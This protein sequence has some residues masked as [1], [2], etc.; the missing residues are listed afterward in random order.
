VEDTNPKPNNPETRRPHDW[1]TPLATSADIRR[2]RHTDVSRDPRYNH[3]G[4]SAVD[5]DVECTAAPHRI[6]NWL[7]PPKETQEL[8]HT[9]H[10]TAS[11][12]IYVIG[13][14]DSPS[15]CP[16]MIDKKQCLLILIEIGLCKDFGY[17]IKI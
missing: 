15:P 4:L 7:L 6:P 17:D 9:G 13:V 5:G 12:L 10:G 11:D 8:F 16:T 3:W 1:L 2:K 14:L